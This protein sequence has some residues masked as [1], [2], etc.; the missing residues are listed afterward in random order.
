LSYLW[1]AGLVAAPPHEIT[2]S[3]GKFGV[4]WQKISRTPS[5]RL[6]L[7]LLQFLTR[8]N[9]LANLLLKVHTREHYGQMSTVQERDWQT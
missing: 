2:Q 6:V 7:G 3:C 5:N 9:V 4:T 8:E 1:L